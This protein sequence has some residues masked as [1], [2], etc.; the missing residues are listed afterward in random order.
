MSLQ[1][2]SEVRLSQGRA[3]CIAGS[4]AATARHSVTIRY[5]AG[6][7][8]KILGKGDNK[9]ERRERKAD[10]LTKVIVLTLLPRFHQK[11]NKL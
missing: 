9:E 1:P 4:S 8:N 3:E 7:G 11:C 6:E 10:V 2:D 5:I